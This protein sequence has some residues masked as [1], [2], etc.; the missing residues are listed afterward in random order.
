MQPLQAQVQAGKLRAIAVTTPKRFPLL[1]DVP[2]IAESG[3]PGF[4]AENWYAFV[5]SAKVPAPLLERWNKELVKV[6]SSPD[7]KEQLARH[8]ME[9]MPGTREEHAR[10]MRQEYDMWGRVIKTAGIKA[11]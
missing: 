3:Y 8:F 4:E 1:P 5:T 7:V 11:D 9:T 6:L 2:A 10:T